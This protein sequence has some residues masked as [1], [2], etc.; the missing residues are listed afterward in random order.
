MTFEQRGRWSPITTGRL[1]KS[2]PFLMKGA[3]QNE[4]DGIYPTLVVESKYL[5]VAAIL[6]TGN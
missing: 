1:W 4:V 5:K 2:K 3:S 6:G